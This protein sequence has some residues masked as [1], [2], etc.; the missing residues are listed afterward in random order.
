MNILLI[1]SSNFFSTYGGGQV[2]VKNIADEMI[3]QGMDITI[4]S[5]DRNS[6]EIVAKGEYRA[7]PLYTYNCKADKAVIAKVVSDDIRPDIIHAHGEKALFCTIGRELNIPVV[8]TAHHGG[9]VCPAG[10]LLNCKDEICQV[11]VSHANCLECVLRNTKTGTFFYPLLKR[12]PLSFRLK[13]GELLTKL[14]F[15]YFVTPILSS[16]RSI[17]NK[18]KEWD[19]IVENCSLMLAPSHAIAQAMTRNG[20]QAE[21]IKIVPHGI[22]LPEKIPPFPPLD[23]GIKFFYAGRFGR[24]KGTHIL[25]QDFNQV[26]DPTVQ[27]HL[28]G[29]CN[30]K[31]GRR[32]QKKYRNDKRIIWHGKIDSDKIYETIAPFHTTT[33][34]TTYLEVFGLHIAEALAMGKPV[35]ATRCGGA[36]MQV[37]NSNGWLIEPNKAGEMRDL[38]IELAK[39]PQQIKAKSIHASEKVISIER[40]VGDLSEIYMTF[41]KK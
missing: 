40:H 5:P 21:K 22:P 38:M 6:R 28:I 11:P 31:Y 34:T 9:I 41:K 20:L 37:D 17:A 23:D 7:R 15:I 12:I 32:L 8:V 30:N 33:T 35:V 27:L 24:I 13:A 19:S 1:S 14:P 39:N 16:D 4:I 18:K 25:L 29:D 10:T 36:E 3:R 2:Y 26:P